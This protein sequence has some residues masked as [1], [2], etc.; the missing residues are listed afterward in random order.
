M[1]KIRKQKLFSRDPTRV[2]MPQTFPLF[3]AILANPFMPQFVPEKWI[4]ISSCHVLMK[5]FKIHPKNY[6]STSTRQ[7][8]CQYHT[9][10]EPEGKR[11]KKH[12]TLSQ[13]FET[14]KR[15]TTA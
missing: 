5:R 11:F 14:N 4:K 13:T 12:L 7:T 9:Q 6:G 2:E 1:E 8:E 3:M 10:Q 15:L